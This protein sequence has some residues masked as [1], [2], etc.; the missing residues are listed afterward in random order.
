MSLIF[1]SHCGGAG[2]TNFFVANTIFSNLLNSQAVN[3]NN[4]AVTLTASN[5]FMPVPVVTTNTLYF[6]VNVPGGQ[7]SG[8]YTQN[9][10]F[11]NVC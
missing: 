1:A 4:N 3:T 5:T 2:A 10:V 11:L 7:A 6:G 9:I 8:Q